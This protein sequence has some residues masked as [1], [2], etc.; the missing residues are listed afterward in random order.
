MGTL[1][2]Q[3]ISYRK[4][5]QK[6]MAIPKFNPKEL[7]VVYGAPS[8]FGRPDIPVYNYPVTP[9]EACI[10]AYIKKAVWQVMGPGIEMNLFTPKCNPDNIARAFVYDASFIPGVTNTTGGKDMFGIEWEFVPQAGGSMVRPGKPFVED[11]NE[12]ANKVIWPDID[13]WDWEESS[14]TNE[15]YLT[16]NKLNSCVFLNGWYE[17]LISFMDF[18]GAVVALIDEDQKEAVKTFFDK[19]TDLYIRILDK[20]IT[21]FPQIDVFSIHDDWGSQKETF[22]SPATAK[23][24]I[25]PYMK[26][27]TDF[28]HSKNKFA[29]LHSCGQL[30]KQVP[31]MIAAGWDAWIPQLMND[32]H[33]IYELYGDKLLVAVAPVPFDP[34]STT[35]EEQRALARA[36][37]DKFCKPEKPSTFN[38]YSGLLGIL[39]PAFREELYKASRI[40]YS[41]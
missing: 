24:M 41:A 25:V 3:Q 37:A 1:Y 13:S 8:L 28:L 19:L 35:E 2:T 26:R 31:N 5:G 27:V 17:R 39:T 21:Y 30:L 12:I 20:Y 15:E 6:L 10:G 29:E 34:A 23:E 11:A 38:M 18:D 7:E 33:K 14:I 9:K 4:A 22:F 32:T 16:N 40:N 36:Y